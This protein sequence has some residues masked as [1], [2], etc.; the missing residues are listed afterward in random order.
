MSLYKRKDSKIWW[1]SINVHGRR[2]RLPTGTQNKKKAEVIHGKALADIQEGKWFEKQKAK[3]ITFSEM[4]TKYLQKYHRIRDEHTLKRLLPVFGQLTLA[5]ITTEMISD[6]RDERLKKVK[7]ATIYQELSLMRRMFNVARREWKWTKE[8]PVADLSFAVGN[9]NARERWL[10]VEEEK[11]L[12]T[13]ATNPFWLKTLLIVA[14]HT[15]MRRAEILNLTWKDIDFNRRLLTVTRSKNGE[16]RAIPLSQTLLS[17]LRGFNRVV[18]L[19]GK[20]FPVS[21][22]CLRQ[23]YDKVLV[24]AGLKD[25]HFHDLRHTFATRL[26][27]NGVDLY[28]VKEL[29]GH[30]TIQMTMRYA[31]HYPESL[32]SSVEVLDSCQDVSRFGHVSERSV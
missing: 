8:N 17:S 24:K 6:Y 7:I 31:H 9:K 27:Q 10:T 13:A 5:E 3:T 22:R 15:G 32:R 28:K 16:K 4:V 19:S 29:L 12:L 20:V 23:A 30:K 26:V 18:D 14:L 25:C 21:V 1:L 11:F 2:L